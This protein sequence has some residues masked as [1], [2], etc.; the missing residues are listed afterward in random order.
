M[1]LE[2]AAAFV[3]ESW[4]LASFDWRKSS[5]IL[6][7]NDKEVVRNFQYTTTEHCKVEEQ[8][9]GGPYV[10]T[11]DFIARNDKIVRNFQYT[12]EQDKLKCKNVEVLMWKHIRF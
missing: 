5:D 11:T 2:H 6:T 10:A 12:M 1:T 4:A 3:A 7:R 8:K 9:Y